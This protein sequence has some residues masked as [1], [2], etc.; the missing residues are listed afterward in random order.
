MAST[1]TQHPTGHLGGQPTPIITSDLPHSYAPSTTATMHPDNVR[2]F[3]QPASVEPPPPRVISAQPSGGAFHRSPASTA[4]VTS[5][6]SPAQSQPSPSAGLPGRPRNRP[7]IMDPPGN[8]ISNPTMRGG[9]YPSP[10]MDHA[11]INPKFVDDVARITYAIQQ[12]L[13]DA[14]RRAIRDNWEKCLLG[15]DFHQAFVLN[16]SIHHATVPMTK[17]AIRD[18][19]SKMVKAGKADLLEH[20]SQADLDV[21]S[22]TILAKASHSFLDKA[23]ELRL[24]TIEAK[25]LVDAL[26]RAERLGYESNDVVEQDNNHQERVIPSDSPPA[27]HS[28]ARPASYVPTGGS[29]TRASGTDPKAPWQCTVCYRTFTQQSAYDHHMRKQVCTRAPALPEG[30]RYSCAHCGQGFTTTVGLQYHLNNKV[31]GDFG[32]T[33]AEQGMNST[34]VAAAGAMAAV[35]PAHT[36]APLRTEFYQYPAAST[37]QRTATYGSATPRTAGTPETPVDGMGKT[38]GGSDPYAH[39]TQSQRESLQE[40]LRQA[41]IAFADRFKAAESIADL[42]ERR[43][44]IDSLRN[45]FGTKQSMIRKKYGVRLRERRTKK[46]IEA[47]RERMGRQHEERYD[48]NA[49]D[50][51]RRSLTAIHGGVP[52]PVGPGRPPKAYATTPVPVPKPAASNTWSTPNTANDNVPVKRELDSDASPIEGDLK[53]RRV[54]GEGTNSINNL[55]SVQQ[56]RTEEVS[57]FVSS[58]SKSPQ[59]QDSESQSSGT[60]ERQLAAESVAAQQSANATTETTAPA[61]QPVVNLVDDD[62]DEEES[63]DESEDDDEGIPAVLPQAVRQGLSQ[64]GRGVTNP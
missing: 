39:L 15:T 19:G 7:S 51:A 25:P 41:E 38:I 61:A 23:L 8:K 16:A 14:V 29:T 11:T 21:V 40:E 28:A 24:R 3:T 48:R 34:A 50:D 62:D 18:F 44:R 42:N 45:G 10:T 55:G 2:R 53:R 13:G 20:F 46:E 30:F 36:T 60:P 43:I 37:P 31:C 26:S 5:T 22:D 33:P 59:S 57:P 32:L 4:P 27:T 49:L 6:Y 47:E 56:S 64:T 1:A 63:S 52:R 17:R 12:S 9:G 35:A 54:D 58:G